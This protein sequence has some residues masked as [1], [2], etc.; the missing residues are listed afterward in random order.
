[1]AKNTERGIKSLKTSFA[2]IEMLYEQEK[3]SLTEIAQHLG[4]A[5]STA[6]EHLNTLME[7]SFVI[8]ENDSYRLGLRFLDM[9]TRAQ[10]HFDPLLDASEGT[11][12][13]LVEETGETV[14][15]VV[16]ENGIAVYIN[17]RSGERS[18]PT[19]A[20]VGR[21][22]LLH[23]IAAGKAI[24][25]TLP[26]ERIEEI[27]AQRGLEAV[28]PNTITERDALFNELETIRDKGYAVNDRESHQQVRAIGVPIKVQNSVV[29]AIGL[30]GPAERLVGGYFEEE[31]PRLM[32]A[33]ANEIELKLAY[34]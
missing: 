32:K 33:S 20:W 13:S 28:T 26:R 16:E 27:I 4:I 7:Y 29:G 30:G 5:N 31:L 11:L 14:N 1:M 23:S 25:A 22:R 8:R 15:L 24:L 34:D 18:I 2:I 12:S 10:Q 21:R 17:R 3:L 19:D 9:G 6:H